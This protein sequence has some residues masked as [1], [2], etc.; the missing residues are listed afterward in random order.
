MTYREDTLFDVVLFLLVVD[1]GAAS[2]GA[3]KDPRISADKASSA[4]FKYDCGP[5]DLTLLA[6]VVLFLD[7]DLGTSSFIST[8]SRCFRSRP[9][10]YA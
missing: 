8:S 3:V 2:L 7:V 6:F 9:G 10:R 1:F 4:Q 5:L